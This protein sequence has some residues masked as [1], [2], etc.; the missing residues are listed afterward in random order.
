VDSSFAPSGV[1]WDL[2][3]PVSERRC[4]LVVR[5]GPLPERV[6]ELGEGELR[7]GRGERAGLRLE[8][9]SVAPL[10]FAIRRE[11]DGWLLEDLGSGAGTYHNG[12]MVLRA[13]LRPGSQIQAGAVTLRFAAEKAPLHVQPS[14]AHRF[15]PVVGDSLQMREIF[16][17]L[18]R[19]S[20]TDATVLLVGETGTGKGA[21][22]RAIHGKSARDGKSLLTVDCS[23]ITE[24]LIES[25]LFGHER[26]AFT[27]ADR[28][29]VG[30]LEAASGGT[31]FIDE[32]DDL[33]LALQPKLLRA[34][35]ERVFQ[36]VGSS[37]PHPFDARIV[38]ASKR[39]LWTLV[40][41]GRFREDLFFRLSV[42]TVRLPALRERPEDLP[43]LADELLGAPV[44]HLL[45][46]DVRERL[47]SHAWPG[48]VRELRNALERARHLASLPGPMRADAVLPQV[49]LPP[50][51]R[52]Q[53]ALPVELP[54]PPKAARELIE[55]EFGGTFKE[56]KERLV[57]AFE[58]EFLS[59]LLQR[60]G[61]NVAAAA[62]LADLDRK[63][64]TDLLRKH[65]LVRKH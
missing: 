52:A 51:P 49:S 22:A 53:P 32:I 56:A 4:R 11:G 17:L 1:P 59:R 43:A 8:H 47:M 7:I 44:W 42:F 23:S 45:P 35:E 37:T 54:R 30:M 57:S 29:R 27:G 33:P 13:W 24:A 9:P 14:T 18:D 40:Q 64:L 62:R 12:M 34:L 41:E 38:A 65:G 16:A 63:H 48:N 46:A 3:S 55:V 5:E 39:D 15:G 25:E 21:F 2:A 28:Q 6:V 31:L 19:I 50:A 61:G 58:R 60:T 36:R 20:S 26:G 10:H